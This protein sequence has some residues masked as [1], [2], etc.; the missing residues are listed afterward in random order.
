MIWDNF[1]DTIIVSKKDIK[2]QWLTR[3]SRESRRVRKGYSSAVSK[4]LT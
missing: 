2:P 4:K 1:Q 3:K